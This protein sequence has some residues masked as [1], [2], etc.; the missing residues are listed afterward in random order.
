[1]SEQQSTD[2]EGEQP[3]RESSDGPHAFLITLHVVVEVPWTTLPNGGSAL[4][5]IT[6]RLQRA[7]DTEVAD[8]P[9]PLGWYSTR[10]QALDP[11]E[12]NCG[13]CAVCGHWTTDMEEPNPVR[14]LGCGARV[15]SRLLCDEHL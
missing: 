10:A 7:I 8:L 11:D 15:D 1:M 6:D 5:A 14:G 13:R 12:V 3:S 4:E 2:A 9:P